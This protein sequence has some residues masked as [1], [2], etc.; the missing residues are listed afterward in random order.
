MTEKTDV[1]AATRDEKRR[2]FLKRAGKASAGVAAT[3]GVL[4]T[5]RPRK[6]AAQYA[7]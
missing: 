7:K 2:A 4:A 5:M 6:A 3:T 1:N